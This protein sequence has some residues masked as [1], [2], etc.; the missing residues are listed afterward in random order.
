MKA[1]LKKCSTTHVQVYKNYLKY[2]DFVH[3][4]VS[5]PLENIRI[6]Y[7]YWYMYYSTDCETHSFLIRIQYP[8]KNVKVIQKFL[9]NWHPLFLPFSD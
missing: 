1:H 9:K 7:I 6:L 8:F 2:Q 5:W 4:A 3:C